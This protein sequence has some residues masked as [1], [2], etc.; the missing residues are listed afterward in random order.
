MNGEP[1][2]A[3]RELTVRYGAG[4]EDCR[5][6]NPPPRCSTCGAILGASNVSF[7]VYP[8]EVLG[9]VGESGSGKSTVLACANLDVQPTYGQVVIDGIDVTHTT[10]STRRKLRNETLGIVYQTPQQGLLMNVTAGGNVASRPLAAGWRSYAAVRERVAELQLGVELP[11]ERLD[12]PVSAFSGGMRQRVQLAKALA[13]TP[14]LLL[15]DEPTSGL[16]VSVQARILDLIRAI[17]RHMSLAMVVVS[18]DL[19]VIRMLAERLVVMHRGRIIEHGLTDQVLDD[20]QHA[21]T[22]LLVSSQLS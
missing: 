13:N 3:V 7:D 11:A 6:P 12:E 22:Q 16:D 19:A 4:C 14:R 2:L 15:L 8:G 9:I 5:I 20:P 18:H 1:V 10:G 21:Y 17:Q